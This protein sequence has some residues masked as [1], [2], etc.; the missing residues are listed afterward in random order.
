M[1]T[2]FVVH[3]RVGVFYP[4]GYIDGVGGGFVNG[5]QF[6]VI[7]KAEEASNL[8]VRAAESE[9]LSLFFGSLFFVFFFV[10]GIFDVVILKINKV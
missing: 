6:I 7:T 9:D 4:V 1:K 8:L 2:L 5:R 3:R 10:E